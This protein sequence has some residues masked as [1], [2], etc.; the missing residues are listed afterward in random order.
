M[1]PAISERI[2]AK[3]IRWRKPQAHRLAMLSGCR[4]RT[5][6]S[7][8][9][10]TQKMKMRPGQERSQTPYLLDTGLPEGFAADDYEVQ[11]VVLEDPNDV[12]GLTQAFEKTPHGL[13]EAPPW[14]AEKYEADAETPSR[15]GLWLL[16]SFVLIAA[17]ATQLIHYNRDELAAHP[18]WGNEVR[19]AYAAL[20]M[21]V[22]PAWSVRS[23]EI[24]GSEAVAGES[25]ADLMDIRAQIA[26]I[27]NNPTGLPYLRVVLRD[28]W[29]NPIAAQHFSPTEYAAADQLPA[30]GIMQPNQTLA[31]HVSIEDPGA[32]A[33]GFEL[34]LCLPRRDTGLECTGQPFK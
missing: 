26:S 2:G 21:D 19:R 24:R 33:Q 10:M 22:Y 13:S 34:E 9:A 11:H 12:A 31:A 3:T 8:T 27:D 6:R 25:G 20:G 29:S 7:K 17:L 14:N 30:D 18:T 28:R 23:Y 4:M 32:G 16:G 5:R 15:K 1:I